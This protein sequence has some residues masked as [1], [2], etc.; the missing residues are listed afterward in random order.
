[1][2]DGLGWLN[3]WQRTPGGWQLEAVV[4]GDAGWE[5]R[6]L[7]A[8]SMLHNR[9]AFEPSTRPFARLRSSNFQLRVPDLSR[10]SPLLEPG[11]LLAALVPPACRARQAVYVVAGEE[12]HAYL[13]AAL[14]LREL[15]LWAPDA[16]E[17]LLTPNS[18][19]LYLKR[20]DGVDGTH[21]EA[22]GALAGIGGGDAGLRRL[23]WLSQC[24]DAQ[25]SW[26]SVL[27]FAHDG[28]LRL[29]LPHASLEAWAWGVELPTGI[30]VAELS[31]VSLTFE[32]PQE[33]F[34]MRLGNAEH[35]CPPAPQRRTGL[36]TF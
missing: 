4:R 23:S 10:L 7:P 3:G 21:V 32:L 8:S 6:F 33:R 11:R 25:A 18:L 28:A 2:T 9:R 35:L 16:L 15:W 12:Q 24:A 20:I 17:A 14:L 19:A 34:R 27:T 22:T 1:M 36:V 30:L 13:P 29:R 5:T 26:S 31:A